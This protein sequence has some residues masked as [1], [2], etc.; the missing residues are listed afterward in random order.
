MIMNLDEFYTVEE[1]ANILK[2]TPETIRRA[3]RAGR[4]AAIKYNDCKKGSWRIS[5]HQFDKMA[6]SYMTKYGEK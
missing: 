2:V 3:I 6:S 5:R 1:F 4:I